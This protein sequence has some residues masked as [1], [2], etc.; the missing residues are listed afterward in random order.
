MWG[1]EG[2]QSRG[3]PDHPASVHSRG[4]SLPG[5]YTCAFKDP[6]GLDPTAL[7]FGAPEP[8]CLKAWPVGGPPSTAA[9]PPGLQP[10]FSLRPSPQLLW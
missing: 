2:W 8:G 3:C 4:S 9:R 1:T 5:Q 7:A 10:L 6:A